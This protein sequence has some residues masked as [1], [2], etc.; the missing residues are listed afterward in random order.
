MDDL[1]RSL[2]VSST[3]VNYNP[4]VWGP[5]G[6]TFIDYVIAGYPE[7]A[8][9]EEAQSMQLFID[10]LA[11]LL[12]CKRCRDSHVVFTSNNPPDGYLNGRAAIQAWFIMYKNK[13]Y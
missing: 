11:V 8:T 3:R 9:L 13:T 4:K 5:P 6:W 10:S 2:A 12:P 1:L 7:T